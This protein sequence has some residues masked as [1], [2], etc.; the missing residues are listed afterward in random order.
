MSLIHKAEVES[1]T[2]SST[3]HTFGLTDLTLF[4]YSIRILKE[5]QNMPKHCVNMAVIIVEA[6]G[7]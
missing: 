3:T 7:E 5:C 1:W 6:V 2:N 4:F